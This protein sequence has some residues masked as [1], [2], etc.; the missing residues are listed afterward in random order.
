MSVVRAQ[1]LIEKASADPKFRQALAGAA[2]PEAKS[3]VIAEYGFG[4]VTKADLEAASHN[5]SVELSDAELETVAGGSTAG[6]VLVSIGL[7]ALAVG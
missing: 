6:W 5:G 7:V 2:S 3:K 1:E 4:D